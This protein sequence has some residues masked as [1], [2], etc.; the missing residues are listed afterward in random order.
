M[1]DEIKARPTTYEGIKMRS[2]LEADYAGWMDRRGRPWEYE[3]TC[4]GSRDGQWLPDFQTRHLDPDGQA[5]TYVELKSAHLAGQ[6]SDEKWLDTVNRIDGYLSKMTV[7]W[8]TKPDALLELIFWEFGADDATTEVFAFG[9][10]RVWLT[11]GPS[12][13]FPLLW[14]GMEQMSSLLHNGEVA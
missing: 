9:Q 14:P 7:A 3:P 6:F 11:M 2:R 12:F 8:Q 10:D 5:G 4:F 1:S 13:A